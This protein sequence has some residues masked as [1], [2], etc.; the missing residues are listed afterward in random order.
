MEIPHTYNQIP[1]FTEDVPKTAVTTPFGLFEFPFMT[2]GLRN[3]AQTFQRFM[4]EVLKGLSFVY[5]YLDDILIFSPN[6]DQHVVHLR[7]LFQRLRNYG[8]LINVAKCGFGQPSIT[9]LGHQLT[10]SGVRPLEDK[11]QAILN[12]PTP[13]NIKEL[14]RFLGV[15]NFYRRFIPKAS[16]IQAPLNVALTGP[17]RKG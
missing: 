13:K 17:K 8:I 11:V 9:F 3:A 6:K 16:A 10:A 15:Y 7:Q 5:G 2:F 1:V 14:R 4:D 12:F